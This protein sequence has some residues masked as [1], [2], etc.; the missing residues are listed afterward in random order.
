MPAALV[1]LLIASTSNVPDIPVIPDGL[2]LAKE[3]PFERC[4]VESGIWLPEARAD[5]IDLQRQACK[6][7]PRKCAALLTESKEK[8]VAE[9]EEIRELGRL[10]GIE[11]AERFP[12]QAYITGGAI[13]VILGGILVVLAN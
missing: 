1:A 2:P 13:G 11:E 4:E 6:V 5:A 7:Y 3:T 10:E 9:H 8:C 12:W